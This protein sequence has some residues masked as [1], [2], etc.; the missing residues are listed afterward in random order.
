MAEGL[1]HPALLQIKTEREDVYAFEVDGHLTREE[2]DAVY[3]TLEKAYEK[4]DSINL[5]IRMGRY[6]GFDWNTLFSEST[7][8]GKLHALKH[9][10]RYAVIG[11]PHWF[12]TAIRLFNPLFRVDVHHFELDDEAEAWRW[13]YER[14]EKSSNST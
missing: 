4:H 9:L 10:R 14:D 5:L 1:R 12:G 7:Y 2:T 6:D 3:A 11:G 8:V 13:I